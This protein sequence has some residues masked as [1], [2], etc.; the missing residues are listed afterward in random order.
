MS[1]KR[2]IVALVTPLV[3]L[4]G[5][6]LS[7]AQNASASG[8]T[9]KIFLKGNLNFLMVANPAVEPRATVYFSCNANTGAFILRVRTVS[10]YGGDGST[11]GWHGVP[12]QMDISGGF[13][14]T[15]EE[16]Q[17][18]L[19]QN[20]RTAFFDADLNGTL[21]ARAACHSHEFFAIQMQNTGDS[22]PSYSNG[23]YL[24]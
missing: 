4:G 13:P 11:L 8:A 10:V 20:T 24:S 9:H 19:T 2:K 16:V 3:L 22:Q 12:L 21:T 17:I 1:L 18:G 14:T 6:S 23:G 7:G 5:L 15:D